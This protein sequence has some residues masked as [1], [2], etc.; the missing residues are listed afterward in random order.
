M[1]SNDLLHDD[2][3]FP[4]NRTFDGSSL[5]F[6]SFLHCRTAAWVIS[7]FLAG[8]IRLV[9]HLPTLYITSSFIY[10]VAAVCPT[11]HLL[12]TIHATLDA[13]YATLL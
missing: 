12:H 4:H 9:F 11:P 1:L 13:L 3:S 10:S 6:P 5:R 8:S 2:L 7:T